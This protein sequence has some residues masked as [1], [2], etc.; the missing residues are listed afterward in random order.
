MDSRND[1]YDE[2]VAATRWKGCRTDTFWGD[3]AIRII[4]DE[5]TREIEES[6]LFSHVVTSPPESAHITLRTDIRAFCSQ[7]VGFIFARVAGIASLEFTLLEGE[8]VILEERMD[9]VVTDRDAEYTG[10]SVGFI[11]QVMRI[12]MSDSL[13][14]LLLNFLPKL[15]AAVMTADRQN[16]QRFLHHQY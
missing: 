16:K 10:E 2:P 6:G 13:R 1:H 3:A 15:E 8:V 7:V 9:R 4:R 12:T 14:Q 5:L 11:K